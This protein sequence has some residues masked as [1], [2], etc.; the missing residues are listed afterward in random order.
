MNLPS[1]NSLNGEI[2]F[3]DIN[4][5][6]FKNVDA[7]KLTIKNSNITSCD[8]VNVDLGHCDLLSSKLYA[9]SFKNVSFNYADIYS[10][11]FS[12]CKFDNVDFSGAGIEDIIF[13]NCQFNNCIFKNVGLK[14]CVFSDSCFMNINP[15]SSSFTLNQYDDCMFKQCKFEGSFQYQIFN[16]CEFDNVEME[17]SLLKYN[18]GIGNKEIRYI[19]DNIQ[20]EDA[21]QL[22]ELL[23]NE[24]MEQNLFLNASFVNFNMLPSINPQLILKSIDAIEIILS[25]EILLRNDELLFLKK[26][27]QFMYEKRMITPILLYQLL[28]KMRN[29]SSLEQSNIAYVKSC[30]FLSLIYNNLYSN[31]FMFCDKLQQTLE[32]L[33]QYEV[34][35]KV[36]ID[37]EQE[38]DIPLAELLNQCLPDTFVRIK[39]EYGCFHEIIKILKSKGYEILTIFFQILG[40]TI[41][42]VQ[43]EIHEKG[44][45]S[46]EDST[47]EKTVNFNIINQNDTEN[48][49]KMIQ[50]TCSMIAASGILNENLQGYNNSNIKKINVQYNINI[51]V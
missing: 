35:L 12:E 6:L 3:K 21:A 1:E 39:G 7:Q 15:V 34:P 38:P 13:N 27:Y 24:C 46:N 18:F 50:Q 22:Y 26:L 36:F 40:I 29:F 25:H 8:F 28:S 16:Q 42:I 48:S 23:S 20:I 44:S 4:Q 17:Y 31:F 14:N 33:P 49:A 2:I 45:K 30:E 5:Q 11:W 9:V 19:K 43:T 41:P 37:Y 10:L 51:Q 32:L 47:V